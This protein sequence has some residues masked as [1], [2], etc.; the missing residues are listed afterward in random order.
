MKKFIS[1][2]ILLLCTLTTFAQLTTEEKAQGEAAALDIINRFTNG[3]MDVKVELSLSPT[4]KGCDKYEYSV[5]GRTL[6][7]KASSA[8][9]ACRGF[10]D[11]VKAKKAGISTWS[12]KRF[13][14]P[15]DMSTA[16]KTLTTQY[17]DHQYMNV[18]T[19][20]YTCPYW[21]EQR[22]DEEIDWMALHGIDM[23]LVLIGAEQVY[24]EVFYDMGLTKA[25]V[26]AWEV[27]PAHLPWFRMGNLAGNSFDGPLGEEWNT[28]Q[29]ALCK[30][31]LNR[32]RQLGMKTVCPAFGGFVPAAFT[33]HHSGTTDATGWN[34]VPQSYRNY[35]L[36]PSS[37]AF[38]EVGRRFLQKW[39][40]KY[41]V[42][43]YYLSDSFNEMEIPNDL[44]LLT[45]YGDSIYKSIKSGSQNP[46]AV[47]VTQG[48]TFV[49]QSG[50]WGSSKFNALTKHIPD[51]DFM[52][53]YMSPEYGPSKCWERYNGFNNKEWCYTL[54]P[55]MGGKTFFTGN[56]QNY[57]QNYLTELYNSTQKGNNLTGYGMTPEGVENNELL[58]E[59][60]TDAGWTPTRGTINL[61]NWF[62]QYTQSRYG[63]YPQA[64]KDYHTV[65]R[66]TVYNKY[67][68]HPRFGWQFGGNITGTGNAS[69]ADDYYKGVEQ[70]FAKADELREHTTPELTADLAEIA[71]LYV[72]GKVEKLGGRIQNAIDL[73]QTQ[74]AD[75]LID[76]LDRLM[77]D[78]DRALTI[79]PKYNLKL[80]EDQAQALAD[81]SQ[82]K[83]RNAKNARRI[84]TVWYGNHTS[85]E[86]VQDYA[87]R[88]WAGLVRDFY[89][90]RLVNTWRQKNGGAKFDHIAFENQ[91][92]NAAPT[93]SVYEAVPA[94]TLQFLAQVVQAAHDAGEVKVDKLGEFT[95]SN[96][97][98][99]HWYTLRCAYEPNINK[100]LTVTGENAALDARPYVAS[101]EQIWRILKINATTY[102]LENR[103]GQSISLNAATPMT[104]VVPI[105]SDMKLELAADD[106][107]WW[108]ILP[109]AAPTNKPALHYNNSMMLYGYKSGSD[110]YA[111]SHFTLEEVPSMVIPE[112][113]SDDYANYR[114][115]LAGFTQTML[116]G[117]LGQPRSEEALEQ[118]LKAIDEMAANIDHET[119]DT[120]LSHFTALW[121]STIVMSKNINVNKLIEAIARAHQL[122]DK[123][124][125]PTANRAL[126]EAI[127]RAE[128]AVT[129]MTSNPNTPAK[130]ALAEL[131]AA[132]LQFLA[133]PT[134]G[135]TSLHTPGSMDPLV[136]Y[137][138]S[139]RPDSSSNHGIKVSRG[140]KYLKTMQ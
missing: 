116:Y 140:I 55:N 30:H 89:R 118:A 32:M 97:Y 106:S 60:I 28:R 100:V 65:L 81:N 86:P 112:A 54:L 104:Y 111:G 114:R 69:M 93:L 43:K 26:D 57:A 78:M 88:V 76:V 117:Q 1:L 85:N 27:G 131:E 126:R 23:P 52:V 22:W 20:G 102:R 25:E 135:I 46:D 44:G 122:Q 83:L 9:A 70:L 53:L 129:T 6:T 119:Y 128:L 127:Q 45:Q 12:G 41:G 15:E 123:P 59:L 61:D 4:T 36:S 77:L 110:Y 120:F 84:V 75:S 96:G 47:W 51:H 21:D 79:H 136:A 34:W 139:G 94:D 121:D 67:I 24:R 101:G 31:V 74:L 137:D 99:N 66:N 40:Q 19:Y 37:A 7:V 124:K 3:Q 39:E 5:S 8:V 49:Y 50:S 91:F 95:V 103:Y 11:Y 62:E 42:G 18:V 125:N 17:R 132:V 13:V 138:L 38:V 56:L 109:A 87:A 14:V 2:F 82:T 16:T 92:V 35:R 72:G 80:W 98:E 105:C 130:E 58:Y 64:L 29:E 133:S 108:A 68:D 134:D 10:Y 63:S 73:K 33:K 48:W 107:R 113:N 90:P 115:R 71:A